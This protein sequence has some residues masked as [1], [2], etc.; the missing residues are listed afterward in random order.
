MRRFRI[1]RQRANVGGH[2]THPS[3]LVSRRGFFAFGVG[4][5][6]SGAVAGAAALTAAA[7][8]DGFETPLTA[9]SLGEVVQVRSDGAL[10]VHR[11][12]NS[13]IPDVADVA[14]AI[15]MFGPG[16]GAQP[17]SETLT[18]RERGYDAA[19]KPGHRAVLIERY[20]DGEW[21]MWGVQHLFVRID[22]QE[23]VDRTNET[24]VT[25]QGELQITAGS[26]TAPEVWERFE[27]VELSDVEAGDLV[28]GLGYVAPNG[29]DVEI[30]ALGVADAES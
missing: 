21:I 27:P 24:L 29:E 13:R 23:V 11:E 7:D 4:A 17:S 1:K 10:E 2:E 30:A 19:W 15:A 5:L 18:V 26:G 20:V 22:P 9:S 16:F 8:G 14:A 6:G 25:D 28:G 3:G 12:A